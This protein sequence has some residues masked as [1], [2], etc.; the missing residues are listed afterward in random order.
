MIL[1]PIK[2][3]GTLRVPSSK[4]Y[5]H[6]ALICAAL[7]K[8]ESK[9]FN[10][11]M[12]DDIQ[13][14]VDALNQLG[15]KIKLEETTLFIEGISMDEKHE[16]ITLN[17]HE[18]GSTL[19]FLIPLASVLSS[20]STFIGTDVLM[21]RPQDV[22]QD[23]Y[24]DKMRHDEDIKVTG[25]LKPKEYTI[26]GDIS[27][28]FVTGL[29]LTLP[30]LDKPSSIHVLEPFESRPYV[31]LT[32][33]ILEKFNVNIIEN[34]GTYYID[35][36]QNYEPQT[37]KAEGD[38]SQ[39]AFFAVLA[40]I[41]NDLS[42][43]NL[44]FNSKQGDKV[45]FEILES[46]GLNIEYFEDEVKVYKG[47]IG[48]GI[49]DLSQCPDLGPILFVLGLFTEEYLTLNNIARLRLK[50]SNR[51]D[52][53][54]EELSKFGAKF[55]LE[56]D[57]ITIYPLTTF[58]KVKSVKSHNDHRIAMALSILSTVLPYPIDLEDSEAINKSYPKFF[59][60]LNALKIKD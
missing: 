53:M 7:S 49:F 40:A 27:S 2:V 13:R 43:A 52:A 47:N 56:G 57:S 3:S 8:G 19:R 28:Q 46:L 59:K 12:N 1:N 24:A 34:K 35:A 11:D 54:I 9:I 20:N 22:Y 18:S 31:D 23:L 16:T 58:K 15:A 30:L 42:L 44:N 51:I 10:V 41:N 26:A 4:S 38:F 5:I 37:L 50:E 36:P 48:S 25:S 55:K 45:I 32:C 6:R 29:L 14:T 39:A 21:S 33:S 60:D 17:A